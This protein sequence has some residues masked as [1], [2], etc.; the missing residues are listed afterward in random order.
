[1]TSHWMMR[2]VALWEASREAVPHELNEL[3]WK[4]PLSMNKERLAEHLC[5]FA[6]LPNVGF[7][8]DR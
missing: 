1:M 7:E 2:A 5:A 3:D 8:R 4:A 6:N